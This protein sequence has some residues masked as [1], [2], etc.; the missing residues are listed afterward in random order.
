MNEFAGL[1]QAWGIPG[2]QKNTIFAWHCEDEMLWA[3]NV[4]LVGNS[5]IWFCISGRDQ[6]VADF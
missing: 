5:K 4:N 1:H 2:I 6:T 3:V